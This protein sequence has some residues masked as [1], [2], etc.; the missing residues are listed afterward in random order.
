MWPVQLPF[1]LSILCRIFFS[2]MALRN[3]YSFFSRS[4]QLIFSILLQH[5]FSKL[6][7]IAGQ[8]LLRYFQGYLRFFAVF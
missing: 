7:P 2:S 1:R 5:H 3:T 8:K 6:C 4:D